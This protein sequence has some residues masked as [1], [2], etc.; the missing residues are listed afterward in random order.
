MLFLPSLSH[1]HICT[2]TLFLFHS[3]FISKCWYLHSEL[4][5]WSIVGLQC[6]LQSSHSANLGDWASASTTSE[7]AL[8][9]SRDASIPQW[10][11]SHK[12][13]CFQLFRKLRKNSLSTAL[14]RRTANLSYK[15]G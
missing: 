11:T 5:S 1:T 2:D 4:I 12:P 3:F 8:V 15:G 6:A 13:F 7:A 9:K 10:D 14:L